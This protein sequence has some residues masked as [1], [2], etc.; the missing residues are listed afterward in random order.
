M[1]LKRFSRTWTLAG[2]VVSMTKSILECRSQQQLTE[3]KL[4]VIYQTV[5]PGY[6]KFPNYVIGD[7][8]YNLMLH[9]LREY[10]TCSPMKKSY[11]TL[12]SARN[13]TDFAFC[14]NMKR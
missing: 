1:I 7:L 3:W 4:P 8:L 9:C 6:K 2:Q 5:V 14:S 11:S 13:P 12:I 10:E